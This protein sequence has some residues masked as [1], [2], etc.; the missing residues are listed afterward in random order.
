MVPTPSN[1]PYSEKV[2]TTSLLAAKLNFCYCTEQDGEEQA[3]ATP[4]IPK[5]FLASWFFSD[6]KSTGYLGYISSKKN[7]LVV[8]P[9]FLLRMTKLGQS[10]RRQRGSS[11]LAK[12]PLGRKLEDKGEERQENRR[13]PVACFSVERERRG[14]GFLLVPSRP[15]RDSTGGK[16]L[17][18]GEATEKG[19]R[20]SCRPRFLNLQIDTEHSSIIVSVAF[21]CHC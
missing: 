10:D 14:K 4:R 17:G 7:F 5:G 11:F 6:E 12:K 15:M 19:R 20:E 2:S 13:P 8:L 1:V 9:V 16:G 18:T 3:L 21:Q